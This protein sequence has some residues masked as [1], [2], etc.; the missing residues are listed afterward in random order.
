MPGCQ[1]DARF[2]PKMKLNKKMK[3]KPKNENET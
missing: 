2:G 1:E 3:L